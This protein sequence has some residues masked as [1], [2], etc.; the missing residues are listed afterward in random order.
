[1]TEIGV[2][3]IDRVHGA[4]AATESTGTVAGEAA[5][6]IGT[7]G[8]IRT[9][10]GDLALVD[11]SLAHHPREPGRTNALRFA[12]L[13]TCGSIQAGLGVTEVGVDLAPPSGKPRVAFT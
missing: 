4:C 7:S 3:V 10:I 12:V 5:V 6:G 1:M 11:V 2:T 9:Q 13:S 8:T